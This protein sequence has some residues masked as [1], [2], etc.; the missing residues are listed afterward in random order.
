MAFSDIL[1][2]KKEEQK[3]EETIFVRDLIVGSDIFTVLLVKKMARKHKDSFKIL[4]EAKLTL[5]NIQNLGPYTIRGEANIKAIKSEFNLDDSEPVHS[6]FYKEMKFHKF[7]SRTKPMTLLEGEDFYTHSH[8]KAEEAGLLDLTMSDVERVN[9]CLI[10][11]RISSIEKLDSTELIDKKN[12]AIHCTNG[13]VIE[14][15]NLY[16]GES[17]YQLYH[18][19]SNKS[20]FDNE[21]VEYLESTK[22]PLA[23]YVNFSF[24][25]VVID[26]E[27]TIFFPLSFTHEWGHFIGDVSN[28]D[29]ENV[30]QVARFVTFVNKEESTEED[31]S[32]KIRLLKKNIEKNFESFKGENYSEQV[33]LTENSPCSKIDDSMLSEDELKK[34]SLT[35]FSYNAPLFAKS[36]DN[37][38]SADSCGSLSYFARGYFAH[39]NI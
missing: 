24:E 21:T 10:E 26:K 8:I 39:K 35:F 11:N 22:T 25:N 14:C 23:L 27:E 36:E 32:K 17:P 33:V 29:E 20:V 2:L 31:I 30:K 7:H 19:L 18:L 28:V 3:K 9:E 16:W 38:N 12:W 34:K 4:S 1:K 6:E 5:E 13:L 37:G 15:E